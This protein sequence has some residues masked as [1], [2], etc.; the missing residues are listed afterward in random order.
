MSKRKMSSWHYRSKDEGRESKG[1]MS[2]HG[3]IGARTK[4][5]R[6]RER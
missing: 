3:T 1:K 4:E 6:V 2:S 5:E